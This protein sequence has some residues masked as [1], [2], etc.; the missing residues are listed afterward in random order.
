[1]IDDG[2]STYPNNLNCG[3]IIT[4]DIIRL[5]FVQFV[6]E[7]NHDY[8][9][10]YEGDSSAGTLL[11]QYAGSSLPDPIIAYTGSMYVTF[12]TNW[13]GASN[14]FVASYQVMNETLI[15][16]ESLNLLSSCGYSMNHV[17]KITSSHFAYYLRGVRLA[18]LVTSH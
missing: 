9:R 13:N 7:Y 6:T 2:Y 14:G 16:L 5:E 8:V 10:V 15:L 12:N 1:M 3:W 4:G 18:V 17:L 11:G